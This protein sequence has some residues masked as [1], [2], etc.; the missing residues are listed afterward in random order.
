MDMR[1]PVE[2]VFPIRGKLEMS[3][4]EPEQRMLISKGPAMSGC[5]GAAAINGSAKT[6]QLSK[7]S[8]IVR[9]F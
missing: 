7:R 3:P 8:I 1:M 5:V 9:L 2:A 4:P 6:K